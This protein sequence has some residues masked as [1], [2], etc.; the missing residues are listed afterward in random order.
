MRR[1][2]PLAALSAEVQ[3]TTDDDHREDA[4]RPVENGDGDGVVLRETEPR[5]QHVDHRDLDEPEARRSERHGR[6]QRGRDRHE[7]HLRRRKIEPKRQE[8]EQ[9]TARLQEPNEER[10]RSSYG[11]RA[12]AMEDALAEESSDA[13]HFRGKEAPEP[14]TDRIQPDQTDHDQEAESAACDIENVQVRQDRATERHVAVDDKESKH[15]EQVEQPLRDDHTDGAR[16]RYPEPPLDQ[17]APVQIAELC[18]DQTVHEPAEQQDF[19]QVAPE[20]PGA[21]LA[22][23]SRPADGADRERQVVHDEGREDEQRVRP[24]QG[25]ERLRPVHVPGEIGDERDRDQG[26]DELAPAEQLASNGEVVG[27]PSRGGELLDRRVLD[28]R[29]GPLFQRDGLELFRP[30]HFRK[31]SY[32]VKTWTPPPESRPW[33]RP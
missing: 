29:R 23:Q 12:K 30:S 19:E 21:T 20:D 31:R 15:H 17:I 4:D 11:Q 18:R 26:R 32:R 7:D 1:T 33:A 6:E 25:A 24:S 13:A 9:Q 28:M 22:Q 2:D 27:A 3:H 16:E 14:R 5:R 8:N 10:H